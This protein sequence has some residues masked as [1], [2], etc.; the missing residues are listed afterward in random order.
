ME[1]NESMNP[2]EV[3]V[4]QNSEVPAEAVTEP[5]VTPPAPPAAPAKAPKKA[6]QKQPMSEKTKTMIAI[7]VAVVMFFV[8]VF[9][10]VF[11]VSSKNKGN[12]LEC[13]CEYCSQMFAYYNYLIE[14]GQIELKEVQGQNS[15]FGD[16]IQNGDVNDFQQDNNQ[17]NTQQNNAS[18]SDN[19][20]SWTTAQIV[21]TYK[22]A[23]AKTHN[24]V[25]SYQKMTLRQMNAPGINDTLLSFA[26][27]VMDK[28]L[29]NNSKNIQGITGGHT[30]LSVSDVKSARAYKSGNNI[31][32][33]MLM[34]EQTDK[35]NGNMYSG[36]VGHAISVV[37]DIDSVIGQFSG[38]GMN[39]TIAD[40]DCTLRYT[41]P[42]VKVA[43]NSNG[44]IINGTWSYVT[45][46]TLN[47]LNISA[48]GFDVPVKQAT[49]IV[50]FVVVLNGGFK[51]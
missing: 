4:G 44:Q 34:K 51:G 17:Q 14:S 47:N 45:N 23:A 41:N 46:I 33:E 31:V 50:D 43:I 27:G 35:G 2:A 42:I 20:S 6:P 21:E 1:H 3:P 16:F 30:N 19:P 15:N 13:D 24:S 18:Q 38:L 37:G 12:G 29:Q 22:H 48:M 40:Q 49:A 5:P 28:A 10:I 26:S 39:A 7:I 36:T 8:A 32:I 11:A 9:S 25:T